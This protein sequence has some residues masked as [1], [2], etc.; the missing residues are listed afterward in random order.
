[1]ALSF[2]F[3]PRLTESTRETIALGST[4]ASMFACEGVSQSASRPAAANCSLASRHQRREA[5]IRPPSHPDAKRTARRA[6]VAHAHHP[7]NAPVPIA[8]VIIEAVP[9]P[10]VST[11]EWSSE[12]TPRGRSSARTE[13]NGAGAEAPTEP[14]ESD[15]QYLY[16]AAV[17]LGTNS[18]HMVIVKA[19]P[20]GRFTILDVEKANVRL[21]S[22]GN[23]GFDLIQAEAE[24]RAIVA[25]NRFKKIA[26]ERN[27]SEANMRVVATSAVREARNKMAFI[28]KLEKETGVSVELISGQEEARLIYV[29][30]LQALPVFEQKALVVDIGGGS[31]EF[32]LG[33]RGDPVVAT[34]LKL[35][36]IRLTERFF[37]GG[38]VTS[39][40]QVDECRRH[41]RVLLADAGVVDNIIDRGGGYEVAIGSSGTVETIAAIA[42]A[43]DEGVETEGQTCILRNHLSELKITSESLTRVANTL[44]KAKTN[45]E[46]LKIPGMNDKR[47]DVVLGGTILLQEIFMALDIKVMKVSGFALREGVIVDTLMRRLPSY[48]PTPDIR[49]SSL[50]HI[51]EQFDTEGRL[52][53]ALHSSQLAKQILEG[54]MEATGQ[55]ACTA[56]LNL[57]ENDIFLLEAATILH[58][59]GI[60]ISHAGYH[61]H[62]YYIV[63]NNDGLMGFS[64]LELEMIAL[65]A[66]FHRKKVPKDK[67]KE[68]E[69]L[70]QEALMKLKLLVA[71]IRVAVA[72]DRCNNGSVDRVKVLQDEHGIVLMATPATGPQGSR[73]ITLELWAARAELP[74]FTKVSVLGAWKLCSYVAHGGVMHGQGRG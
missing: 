69:N 42:A 12:L 72:L 29:G 20:E 67:M 54:M 19:T 5:Y 43:I 59:V 2:G 53:S 23:S 52:A 46:R 32:V 47:A 24:E 44:L 15:K 25:V 61:K 10:S 30:V 49:R 50:M 18:F 33:Q 1:M 38:K 14:A 6:V 58:Y 73:D 65:T 64:P 41:I 27:V 45:E 63:K 71:V 7:K 11:S 9:L 55:S 34:S 40:N 51:A 57:N 13:V 22:G 36:H 60:F 28:R 35:G 56:C 66:R 37:Q 3:L 21:G 39:D 26:G 16:L 4:G 68:L 31:T 17:D 70:P 48:R 62:S 74:Y 8:P